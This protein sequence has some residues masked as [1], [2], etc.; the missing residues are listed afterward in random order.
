MITRSMITRSMITRSM[1]TRN[2]VHTGRFYVWEH[3]FYTAKRTGSSGP[4]DETTICYYDAFA[5]RLSI[6]CCKTS[7]TSS[8]ARPASS[9]M[10]LTA[11]SSLRFFCSNNSSN[12]RC[13]DSMRIFNALINSCFAW[14]FS[15]R[16]F[17]CPLGIYCV[18]LS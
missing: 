17:L 12:S 5:L 16:D 1:I 2:V 6:Y 15:S 9:M 13:S 11:S 4:S 8:G 10:S 18:L 3:I 7:V 14:I